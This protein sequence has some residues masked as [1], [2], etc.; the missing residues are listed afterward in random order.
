MRVLCTVSQNSAEKKGK[1]FDQWKR[2][3]K[4]FSNLWIHYFQAFPNHEFYKSIKWRIEVYQALPMR[5]S[6]VFPINLLKRIIRYVPVEDLS[7]S[8]IWRSI[9]GYVI[10]SCGLKISHYFAFAVWK[11]KVM[12]HLKTENPLSISLFKGDGGSQ[13]CQSDGAFQQQ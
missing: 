5:F 10:T 11:V 3:P 9:P 7:K 12:E 4:L 13:K 2:A 8:I 1:S 6:E